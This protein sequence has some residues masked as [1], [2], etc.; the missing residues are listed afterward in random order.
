MSVFAYLIS[1]LYIHI[2]FV[3]NLLY[4]SS[5]R[6]ASFIVN[7]MLSSSFV[8][9]VNC[10]D[11]PCQNGGTCSDLEEGGVERACQ[12]NFYGTYCTSAYIYLLSH[13]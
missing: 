3:V 8:E 1:L 5:C 6:H 2:D 7:N 12:G 11:Q 4:L 10:K 13:A 9:Q